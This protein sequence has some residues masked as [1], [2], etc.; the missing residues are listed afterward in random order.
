MFETTDDQPFDL[1]AEVGT[2]W[3]AGR[4]GSWDVRVADAA[5]V[6]ATGRVC[7]LRKTQEA[8]RIALKSLRRK[9]SK[10]GKQLQSGNA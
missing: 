7:A 6:V 3:R 9:A 5:G 10:K 4:I 1:L 8:I 2:L